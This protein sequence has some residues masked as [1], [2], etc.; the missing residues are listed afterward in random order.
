MKLVLMLL[1]VFSWKIQVSCD[2]L[3]TFRGQHIRKNG[4]FSAHHERESRQLVCISDNPSDA[5]TWN[6]P[7]QWVD[8]FLNW[9]EKN[10]M[11]AP[12]L[13]D[14]GR[15]NIINCKFDDDS[16]PCFGRWRQ[17]PPGAWKI[18]KSLEEPMGPVFDSRW[19]ALQEY[20]IVSKVWIPSKYITTFG[21]TGA[22]AVSVRGESRAHF[23]LCTTVNY[24]SSFCYWIIIGFSQ[25][26]NS[27]ATV[28][29]CEYDINDGG[30]PRSNWSSCFYLSGRNFH[31][32]P[33]SIY[34]WKTFVI[35]WQETDWSIK[36]YDPYK[37][38]SSFFDHDPLWDR[39]GGVRTYKVYCHVNGDEIP[40]NYRIHEYSYTLVKQ[41]DAQLT[42]QLQGNGTDSFCVELLIGLCYK[43][44]LEISLWDESHNLLETN[45]FYGH[46]FQKADHGLPLWQNVKVNFT[47]INPHSVP[48]TITLITRVSETGDNLNYRWA[49]ADIHECLPEGTVKRMT[50]FAVQEWYAGKYWWPHIICQKFSQD[51]TGLLAGPNGISNSVFKPQGYSKNNELCPKFYF[52]PHC[53]T[54]C[55]TYFG[56]DCVGVTMCDPGFCYCSQ[57]VRGTNCDEYCYAGFYGYGCTE[58]CGNC[59]QQ[60]NKRGHCDRF[61]GMCD[62]CRS[63]TN[64]YFLPPYCKDAVD[65]PGKPLVNYVTETSVRLDI[66]MLEDYKKIN[67]AFT[68]NLETNNGAPSYLLARPSHP[69]QP[70]LPQTLTATF[71]GLIPGIQ[72]NVRMIIKIN[73][74]SNYL[75]SDLATFETKCQSS[76]RYSV[77][78][79]ETSLTVEKVSNPDVT[80]HCP[81]S[82]YTAEISAVAYQKRRSASTWP[83]ILSD[84]PPNTMFDVKVIGLDKSQQYQTQVQTLE[85]APSKVENL[86]IDSLGSTSVRITWDKPA[87]PNGNIKTYEIR[88]WVDYY[89]GCKDK[90]QPQPSDSN[91]YEAKMTVIPFYQTSYKIADLKPYVGYFVYVSAHHSKRGEEASVDFE[92]KGME[93]PSEKFKD[94][95]FMKENSSLMWK[96]PDCSTITGS[97][98]GAL[99]IFTGQSPGVKNFYHT[100]TTTNSNFELNTLIYRKIA[101]HGLET[102]GVQVYV[103]RDANGKQY[104]S[105][106]FSSLNFTTPSSAPPKVENLEIVEVDSE[107]HV[108]TLRWQ[109][110]LPPTNGH[111]SYYTVSFS[112][113]GRSK[114]F[115]AGANDMCPLWENWLCTTVPNTALESKSIEVTAHNEGVEKAGVGSKIE[116][117]LQEKEADAPGNIMYENVGNGII[118]VTWSHPWKTG[119]PLTKFNVT[120]KVISTNLSK[121]LSKEKTELFSTKPI[122]KRT[123][124]TKYSE[125]MNLLPSTS[126][127]IQ[128]RGVGKIYP[129]K[130]AQLNIT[131][132]SSFAFDA[133]QPPVVN[134]EES[135]IMIII[136]A[137]LNDTITNIMD[138]VVIGPP[139][140]KD[141]KMVSDILANDLDLDSYTDAWS[142]ATFATSKKANTPF[143]IGDGKLH[144]NRYNNTNCQVFDGS[145]RIAFLVR[146]RDSSSSPKVEKPLSW[147]SDPI[148][149]SNDVMKAGSPLKWILPLV[150]IVVIVCGIT[151]F[152]FRRYRKKAVMNESDE[153]S[154][155]DLP[156]PVIRSRKYPRSPRNGTS[157]L[158]GSQESIEEVFDE[159]QSPGLISD[160]QQT[161]KKG[162]RSSLVKLNEFHDYVKNGIASGELVEQYDTFPR[163]QTK[164]WEYGK[165]PQNRMKNRYANLIAYDETRVK[166]EML[167]D[168]P[169]SDYINAN[170]IP[171]YKKTR[172]YIATQ[173]PKSNTLNDFW[174]MIW[175][176]KVQVICMLANVMEG[177]KKKCEQYWPDIGKKCEFGGITVDN[178]SHTVFADYTFRIF[179]MTCGEE[180]RK[181]E[182]LHYTAWPDHGVPL[183]TQSVVTYLKKL[184]ATSTG[185]GPVVI[186]CSAGIG[187]TGTII[188][189]DIC[190]RRAAAEGVVD[191]FAETEAI[192]SQR[193]NMVDN[194]QQ[195]LL[196]HLTL[197]EC[198]LT[199]PTAIAC[200]ESLPAKIEEYRPRLLHQLQRLNESAWQDE[201][202]QSSAS[203]P[204]EISKTNIPKNRYPE[205]AAV[206]GQ[207]IYISRYPATDADS[208]YMFGVYV[209]SARN[210][211]NYIA[212]QLPLPSTVTDFWRMIA[213]FKIELVI[214]LQPPD[215]NDPTCCEFATGNDDEIKPTPFLTLRR[216]NVIEE[217]ICTSQKMLLTDSSAKPPREQPVTVLSLKGWQPGEKK[218]PP[219][220]ITLV[221]FWQYAERISRGDGPTLVLCHD[222]VTNCGLY[223]ALSFLLERMGLERECD[224]CLAIRAMRRSRPDFCKT[225]DHLEY[226][227]D[228]AVVYAD[229]FET[230]A[231]FT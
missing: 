190:L 155:D 59:L 103:T 1:T 41:P 116:N 46:A 9:K 52:G 29:R 15:N 145:Y 204:I 115:K 58:T 112:E 34:E 126:Y 30:I 43:C 48:S 35:K 139:R 161:G 154:L 150:L 51:G 197:V 28:Q 69:S 42:A 71:S 113:S 170:Y 127:S 102:Y 229:Y 8:T 21:A 157:L 148:K 167:P 214:A 91:N 99:L 212:S 44:D 163:G 32:T 45:T 200:N 93:I 92:T 219:Q 183:Y 11:T 67:A 226:L 180:N 38:A 186:H 96:D 14:N 82:W 171:G 131:T 189:C 191:V 19:E 230:Y 216:K 56:G 198:L 133:V 101:L 118:N 85:A 194:K 72:Y 175:Q 49:I 12:V 6:T 162:K 26:S 60:S 39:Q 65:A 143:T 117:R 231:N 156:L 62:A 121:P 168:E 81:D 129:G 134:A 86:K 153:K 160:S 218:P 147:K 222:G 187:R 27:I 142:V 107:N 149:I 108:T 57:G 188:L 211:N 146:D 132:Q 120:L 152:Y 205:L 54:K 151:W 78:A 89:R 84:L 22:I 137:I 105:R 220:P 3:F 87:Y 144:Y 124:K 114:G 195:Y 64:R 135:Q 37:L 192:R 228:A 50:L 199:L 94:L 4:R 104:H 196:A 128:I 217:D 70:G 174:R 20:S 193:A 18:V 158:T 33:L 166:L 109:K 173:G 177:G 80:N 63:S 125:L 74:G 172:A 210:R 77:V 17:Q 24:R 36:I 164:S 169:F 138:V 181:V 7:L 68:F 176:E 159:I 97:I 227:Y 202:L 83:V 178:I 185:H 23:F 25:E 213:E 90:N 100:E 123:Y 203:K 73:N 119:G 206:V 224:V 10:N 88:L 182:H 221:D 75:Y 209:D 55:S 165:L 98:A 79:A 110:P 61:T 207:K 13:S 76:A 16:N 66:P 106:F 223:L 208:D 5:M 47:N 225:L 141:I 201:A 53:A 136:P 2:Q 122:T 184:L 31:P 111:I 215:K 95:K 179:N 140:C 130:V 40:K